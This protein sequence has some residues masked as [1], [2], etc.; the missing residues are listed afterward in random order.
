MI[1]QL[2]QAAVTTST[3]SNQATVST[4]AGGTGNSG[5]SGT[6]SQATL[7]IGP[8]GQIITSASGSVSG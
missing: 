2:L 6:Q 8:I 4:A 5:P 3:T 1:T 7:R